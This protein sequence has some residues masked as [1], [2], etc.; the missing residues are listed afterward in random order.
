MNKKSLVVIFAIFGL[1]VGVYFLTTS[2]SQNG[3][4]AQD[5][6]ESLDNSLTEN[7]KKEQV[8]ENE[9]ESVRE[10]ENFLHLL[11]GSD[12]SVEEIISYLDPDFYTMEDLEEI[13]MLLEDSDPPLQVLD[14][15][16]YYCND[17]Y[18]EDKESNIEE[19]CYIQTYERMEGAFGNM[20]DYYLIKKE[21]LDNWV[22]QANPYNKE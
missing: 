4:L 8:K 3:T 15:N 16:L 6:G 22:I 2:G 13:S 20:M 10:L 18:S 11:F 1:I 12:A 14:I 9:H 7:E 21:G 17:S 19:L 5:R